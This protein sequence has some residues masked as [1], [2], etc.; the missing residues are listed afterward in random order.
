MKYTAPETVEAMATVRSVPALTR[1]G[2][3]PCFVRLAAR[4]KP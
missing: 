3:E 1:P 4:W 2:T